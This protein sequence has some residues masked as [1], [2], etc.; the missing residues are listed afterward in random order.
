M[1]KKSNIEFFQLYSCLQQCA[2]LYF[3][4]YMMENIKFWHHFLSLL[5][6]YTPCILCI[7]KTIMNNM[8]CFRKDI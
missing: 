1:T 8:I 4:K 3:N 2:F 5:L 7:K 6:V